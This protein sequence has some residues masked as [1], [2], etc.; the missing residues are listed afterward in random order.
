MGKKS[1]AHFIFI[2]FCFTL[3]P[4]TLLGQATISVSLSKDTAFIGDQIELSYIIKIP[5]GSKVD[6]LDFSVLDSV[7]NLIYSEENEML[8]Q[9]LDWNGT[10]TDPP[11][12]YE[13]EQ[14]IA[15]NKLE[16][17]SEA[18]FQ[19]Y[20]L[21]QKISVFSIGVFDFPSPNLISSQAVNIIPLQRPRLI[22]T[23]PESLVEKDSMELNPIKPIIQTDIALEDFLPYIYG[24]LIL[25]VLGFISKK[26]FTKKEVSVDLE[27]NEEIEIIPA[28]VIALS[29]LEQLKKERL[30]EL[31]KIKE[32]QSALTDIIRT[33]L[34]NRF[35]VRAM[36]MTTDEISFALSKTQ[37]DTNHESKLREILQIADLIKFAKAEPAMSIHERFLD[38]AIQFVN[39]TKLDIAEEGE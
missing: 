24:I 12:A 25:L 14:V 18:G 2:F 39:D 15:L 5:S 37:F 20:S 38:D 35:E 36:E 11:L 17:K 4:A 30:W 29:G 31:G 32:Y 8:D 6:G 10:F 21:K 19:V 1:L 16:P 3:L 27:E 22:I 34:E 7:K 26:L 28:H 33:Y 13:S 23:Y 9:V